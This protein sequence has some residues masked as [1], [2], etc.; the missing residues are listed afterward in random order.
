[1]H[2]LMIEVLKIK[3]SFAKIYLSRNGEITLSFCDVGK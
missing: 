3:K 1:M 2:Q